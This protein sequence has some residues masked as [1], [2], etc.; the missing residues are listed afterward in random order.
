MLSPVILAKRCLV[1]TFIVVTIDYLFWSRFIFAMNSPVMPLE[2][3]VAAEWFCR[4]TVKSARVTSI[5]KLTI[6]MLDIM[7]L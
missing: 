6:N 5:T 2:I 3:I 7:I 4:A 1:S